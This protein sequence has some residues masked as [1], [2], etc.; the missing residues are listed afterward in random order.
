MV[1][2]PSIR[3]SERE[4]RPDERRETRDDERRAIGWGPGGPWFVAFV[5]LAIAGVL[6]ALFA[7]VPVPPGLSTAVV[8]LIVATFLGSIWRRYRREGVTR[9]AVA[10][11]THLAAFLVLITSFHVGFG[12]AKDILWAIAFIGFA[13]AWA[14]VY[15]RI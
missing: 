9:T 14:I 4:E 11:M 3:A 1:K 13:V 10:S 12:L 6:V 2:V 15:R 8:V 5:L 7:G